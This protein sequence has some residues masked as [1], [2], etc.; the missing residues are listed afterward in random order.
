MFEIKRSR[1][2]NDCRKN[3]AGCFS[4]NLP[5]VSQVSYA[6]NFMSFGVVV[7]SQQ[8]SP[9]VGFPLLAFYMSPPEYKRAIAQPAL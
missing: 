8:G 1:G 6:E 5:S 9:R 7:M 4:E 3:L 2:D